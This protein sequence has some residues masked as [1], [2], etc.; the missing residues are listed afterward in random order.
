M[1]VVDVLQTGGLSELSEFEPRD[2]GAVFFPDP[3]AFHQHCQ[4]FVET[5]I[6]ALRVLLL[7]QPGLGQAVELH[8]VEFFEGLFGQHSMISQI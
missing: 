8:G 6:T 4:A 7:F 2:Q 1:A 5:Q 3:L